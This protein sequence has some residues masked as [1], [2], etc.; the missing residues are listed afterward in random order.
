M[1][2]SSSMPDEM[3]VDQEFSDITL[4]LL[5]ISDVDDFMTWITDDRLKHFWSGNN[6]Q[7]RIDA[8]DY[9]R[10]VIIPHYW[11]RSICLNNRPIGAVTITEKDSSSAELGYVIASKYWGKGIVTHVLKLVTSTIFLELSQLERLEAMVEVE[12]KA[13]QRVLE[14][15]GFQRE[16]VLRKY[17][18]FKGERRDMVMFSLLSTDLIPQYS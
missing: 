18:L 13:S 3:E 1:D 17:L 14:K 11:Y 9:I 8:L 5:D 16:G 7:T 10:K 4:R 15:V 2:E 12:N 6:F